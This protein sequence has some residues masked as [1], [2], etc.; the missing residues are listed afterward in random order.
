VP[1][2]DH[3]GCDTGAGRAADDEQPRGGLMYRDELSGWFRRSTSIA[4]GR[5]R[6][7]G[8]MSS[9]TC[10]ATRAARG[11]STALAATSSSP[12]FFFAFL[13]GFS[14]T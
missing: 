12:I 3:D 13:A 14:R 7:P 6:E 10:S 1:R 9:F 11:C 2:D 5:R 8:P 4:A